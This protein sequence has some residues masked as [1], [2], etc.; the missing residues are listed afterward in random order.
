M[1]GIAAY[2]ENAIQTQSPGRIVVLLYEGA[3]KFL[4]LTIEE[5]QS[6][7]H[8]E[9]ARYMNRALDII[10]ELNLTLNM[11]SGGEVAKNLRRLYEFMVRHI[12]QANMASN[13]KGL[14]DVIKL[15]EELNSGWKSLNA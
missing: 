9:K 4:R 10:T 1:N 14:E 2:R 13:P 3:I 11:D 5:M 15:L 6:G 8:D 12:Y 7:R